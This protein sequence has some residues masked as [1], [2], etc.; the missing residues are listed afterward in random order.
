MEIFNRLVQALYSGVLNGSVYGLMAIGLT[1]IWGSLRMLNLAHGALYIAGAHIAY[2][3]RRRARPPRAGDVRPGGRW[4]RPGRAVHP[5]HLDQP[6][7]GEARPGQR[8]ADRN[9]GRLDHRPEHDLAA[10]RRADE[11]SG[12]GRA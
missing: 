3:V 5:A 4:R 2:R 6:H 10:L 8:G 11:T 9:P 1:L 12:P 7:P